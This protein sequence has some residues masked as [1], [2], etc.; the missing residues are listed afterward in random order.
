MA[1]RPSV[2]P[3][4]GAALARV[5]FDPGPATHLPETLAD[6]A[7]RVRSVMGADLAAIIVIDEADPRHG[8]TLGADAADGV[9]AGTLAP[10]LGPDDD[11]L[12][13]PGQAMWSGSPVVWPHLVTEAAVL[14]RLAELAAGGLD[15]GPLRELLAGASG[16]AVPWRPPTTRA[17][18]PC[19][20]CRSTPP[21]RWAGRRWT[22][23]SRRPGSCRSP[24]ATTSGVTATAAR[25]RCWRPW[26]R[27]HRVR[28]WSPICATAC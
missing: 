9:P 15:T 20:W 5:L 8:T 11:L 28:W 10:V 12:A 3:A 21:A 26:S 1:D 13:L 18:G 14:D 19:A 6:L 27:A 2:A 7:G 22:P 24:S 25:A 17:L 23:W 4:T 16:V